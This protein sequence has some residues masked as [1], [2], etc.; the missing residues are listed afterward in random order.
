MRIVSTNLGFTLIEFL[1]AIVIMMVGLLGLLQA[2]NVSL[3]HNKI[4]E[5]RL[6][7]TAVA[8]AEM[9]KEMSKGSGLIGFQH[10]STTTKQYSVKKS[11]ASGFRSYSVVKTGN[12]VTENTKEVIVEV[13]WKHRGK[14]YSQSSASLITVSQ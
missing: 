13:R 3:S 10:I 11:I 2:I 1:V 7:A 5:L 14:S 9:V 8:D 12:Q 4:N 6:E